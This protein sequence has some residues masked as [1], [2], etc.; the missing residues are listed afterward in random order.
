VIAL[1]PPLAPSLCI[2]SVHNFPKIEKALKKRGG[3]AL[4]KGARFLKALSVIKY[5]PPQPLSFQV[6]YAHSF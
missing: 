5:R 2:S 6:H 4:D 3:I 1:I